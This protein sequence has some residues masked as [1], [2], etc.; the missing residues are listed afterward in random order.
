VGVTLDTGHALFAGE[1]AAQS[2]ALLSQARRLFLVH[3]NDNYR[4]WDWDMVPGSVNFW[5]FLESTYYLMR[6]YDGWIA[7]DVSPTRLDPTQVMQSSVRMFQVAEAMITQVGPDEIA[8]SIAQGPM[9]SM[10]LFLTFLEGRLQLGQ[11]A[12]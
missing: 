11:N 1:H 7:F 5:D 12:G 4:N 2:A 8:G 3:G 10:G 6:D 9:V